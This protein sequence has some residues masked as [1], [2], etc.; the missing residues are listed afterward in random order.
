MVD[1]K[2]NVC[3]QAAL[4]N[5]AVFYEDRGDFKWLPGEL[6][7][8]QRLLAKLEEEKAEITALSLFTR[9][10]RTFNLPSSGKNPKFSDFA[11]AEKPIGYSVGRRLPREMK[12]VDHVLGEPKP[13]G[14]L[15]TIAFA[16][17]PSYTL[18]IWVDE[19]NTKNSWVL[20]KEIKQ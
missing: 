7:P 14:E 8:W 18:E 10:G 1:S 12:V 20:I 11:I 9:D 13:T 17:Y 5:G 3:W 16:Y 15:F 6:S 2:H 19:N 4:S